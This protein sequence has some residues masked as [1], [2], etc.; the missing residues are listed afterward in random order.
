[1][2]P[3]TR[4][5]GPRWAGPEDAEALLALN[6]ACPAEGELALTFD[7]APDPF[8]LPRLLGEGA[9][10]AVIEDGEGGLKACG[11]LANFPA[12]HLGE[13]VERVMY[14]FDLRV[15]PQARR[16][17]ALKRIYDFLSA[18]GQAE[19]CAL[20]FTTVMGGNEAMAPVLAGKGRL[21][22]YRAVGTMQNATL[23]ILGPRLPVLGVKV[24]PAESRDAEAMAEAWTR[25]QKAKAF[26]P[27]YNAEAMA[28]DLSEGPGRWWLAER[29]GRLVA[30]AHEWDQRG[31]KRLVVHRL[32]RLMQQLRPAYNRL[33]PLLGG[34]ALPGPGE[35]MPYLYLTRVA[36]EDPAALRALYA[37]R[38]NA[39]L[40]QGLLYLSTMLD[41]RDPLRAA[42]RGFPRQETPIGLYALD[43]QGLWRPEW[44]S[45]PAYFDPAWV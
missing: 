41:A 28:L 2:T 14:A 35:A 4:P 12:M 36:A 16:G 3:N 5:G 37:A 13:G 40:G 27:A 34:A 1:M 21:V 26:A 9:R 25:W 29:A 38:L 10:H 33:A 7:R 8:A 22:P 23:M 15:H 43:P 6:R 39:H 44:A 19:G 30:M 24:R 32:P 20:G 11:A 18:W 45:G 31:M 17:L 42:W